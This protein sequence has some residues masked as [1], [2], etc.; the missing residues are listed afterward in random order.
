MGIPLFIVSLIGP[1][2]VGGVLLH[3]AIAR[4]RGRTRPSRCGPGWGGREIAAVL[5]LG[6]GAVFL[7]VLAP[8][9]GLALAWT[10]ARWSRRDKIVATC[11]AVVPI[12]GGAGFIELE[13]Q[14]AGIVVMGLAAVL[15]PIM[16]AVYLV[17][18]LD[19][20]GD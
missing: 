18:S 7:P 12:L 14:V 19:R 15:G 1:F 8:A 17:F 6:V 20:S 2:V 11:V 4:A 16:A 9:V 5:M 10:S 3:R 13:V